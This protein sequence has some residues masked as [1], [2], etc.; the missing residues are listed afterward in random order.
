VPL[1]HEQ[2]QGQGGG[3]G[4]GDG[5]EVEDGVQGGGGAVRGTTQATDRLFIDD[6]TVPAGQADGGGI[7]AVGQAVE[8][9]MVN[10]APA[11]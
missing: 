5:S 8:E 11:D 10:L 2:D 3:Q 4:F 7:D 1:L 6:L 9:D